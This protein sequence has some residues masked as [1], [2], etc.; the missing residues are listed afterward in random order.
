MGVEGLEFWLCL[1]WNM[2]CIGVQEQSTLSWWSDV[3]G[4]YGVGYSG[5]LKILR[6]VSLY[7]CER[8][9]VIRY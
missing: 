6:I 1:R 9:F 4:Y 3:M 8:S 7:I 2:A 5:F